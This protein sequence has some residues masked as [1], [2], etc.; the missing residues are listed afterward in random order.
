[1]VLN[2]NSMGGKAIHQWDIFNFNQNLKNADNFF[3]ECLMLPMNVFINENNS[4]INNNKKILH[5]YKIKLN[6]NFL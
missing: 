2:S 1:M 6:K 4:I 5:K 3:N